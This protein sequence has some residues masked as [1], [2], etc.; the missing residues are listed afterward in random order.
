MAFV[1]ID[2]C[3]YR[4]ASVSVCVDAVRALCLRVP[5][6]ETATAVQNVTRPPA[7]QVTVV[8]SVDLW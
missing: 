8:T 7:G 6:C 5:A 2:V 1:G 3:G 4:F